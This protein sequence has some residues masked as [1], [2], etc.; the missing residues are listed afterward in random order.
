MKTLRS[1]CALFS[2]VC[3]SIALALSPIAATPAAAQGSIQQSGPATPLD[4]L[5]FVGN[6][7][8]K[9]C[10]FPPAPNVPGNCVYRSINSGTS[11]V[12]TTADCSI[13][14]NSSSA[15]VKTE[16]L[17]VCNSTTKSNVVIVGDAYGNALTYAITLT[18][19]GSDTINGQ[20]NF[21]LP[22]SRQSQGLAC[23]G[24]G[25]WVLQ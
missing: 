22:F 1:L 14:W 24:S 21:I 7:I 8:A 2:M 12:V 3:L 13:G 18:P 9:D 16:F 17:Y 20:L 19:N 5:C 4:A 10:G 11:D 25:N 15:S 6:G 23:N